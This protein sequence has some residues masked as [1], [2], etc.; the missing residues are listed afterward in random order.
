MAPRSCAS[1]GHLRG[2]AVVISPWSSKARAKAGGI[3]KAGVS[4]LLQ[5]CS[6]RLA[7]AERCSRQDFFQLLHLQDI[8][9]RAPPPRH[10]QPQREADAPL[11]WGMAVWLPGHKSRGDVTQVVFVTQ[12][13]FLPPP[14]AAGPGERSVRGERA[15]AR[16]EGGKDTHVCTDPACSTSRCEAT[17][18]SSPGSSCAPALRLL[19]G[20]CRCLQSCRW[21]GPCLRL[22]AH[23]SQRQ[24]G[25]PRPLLPLP[26]L[27]PAGFAGSEAGD[28]SPPMAPPAHWEGCSQGWDLLP[29][30]WL[31]PGGDFWAP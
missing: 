18:V 27:R 15:P 7:L 3:S 31:D 30:A 6:A 13:N 11:K 26:P 28:A 5:L 1:A 20:A 14:R 12:S 24:P 23:L 29:E 16:G 8:S 22:L 17:D 10:P 2:R 9:C 25:S 19:P 4:I 21:I